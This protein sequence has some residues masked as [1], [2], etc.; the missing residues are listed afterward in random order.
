MSDITERFILWKE[1]LDEC[2]NLIENSNK[3]ETVKLKGH[4]TE[5][6]HKTIIN[7]IF[8]KNASLPQI[9][10]RHMFYKKN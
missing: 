3:W 7:E 6:E 8:I 2:E 10:K 4:P 1:F 9:V 5:E